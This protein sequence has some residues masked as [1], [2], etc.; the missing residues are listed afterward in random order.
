[1]CVVGLEGAE[2]DL[3]SVAFLELTVTPVIWSSLASGG[4]RVTPSQQKD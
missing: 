1:M 2:W 3:D 4:W